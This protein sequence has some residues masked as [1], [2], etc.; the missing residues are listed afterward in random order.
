MKGN[1]SEM[2]V[3]DCFSCRAMAT[4]GAYSSYFCGDSSSRNG[5][6]RFL[7]SAVPIIRHSLDSLLNRCKTRETW[8]RGLLQ[9]RCGSAPC[10]HCTRNIR[11]ESRLA[12]SNFLQH[13]TSNKVRMKLG[14]PP[15]SHTRPFT[16]VFP[17]SKCPTAGA[18]PKVSPKDSKSLRNV[19]Q[20]KGVHRGNDEQIHKEGNTQNPSLSYPLE[21][22]TK[23]AVV[24]LHALEQQAQVASVG[25]HGAR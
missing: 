10:T 20:R 11:K 5:V 1:G 24:C 15:A 21:R 2:P 22:R 12:K 9:C 13:A 19:S 23:N 16:I 25:S 6:K 14:A 7:P 8:T 3:G 17:I 4:S 18:K